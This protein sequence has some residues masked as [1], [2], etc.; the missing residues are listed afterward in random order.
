MVAKLDKVVLKEP[1]SCSGRGVRYIASAAGICSGIKFESFEAPVANWVRNV[2]GQQGGIMY[3]TSAWSFNAKSNLSDTAD[4]QFSA[5]IMDSIT[6]MSS[7]RSHTNW[8]LF[9]R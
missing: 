9:L 1:W 7:L 8:R 2:I 6:E 5:Q 3:W 4:C